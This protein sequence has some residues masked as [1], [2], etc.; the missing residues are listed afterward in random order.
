MNK[1]F[2]SHKSILILVILS[3]SN[4]TF[5]STN[6]AFDVAL[7]QAQNI[8]GAALDND[9]YQV[10]QN[11]KIFKKVYEML[12]DETNF[13]VVVEGDAD[14]RWYCQR[15]I[16]PNGDQTPAAFVYGTGVKVCPILLREENHWQIS[17]TLIHEAAHLAGLRNECQATIIEIEAYHAANVK[18][19]IPGYPQCYPNWRD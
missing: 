4:T 11:K 12:L 2:F 16:G 19:R 14:D 3:I 7:K 13:E 1:N 15:K 6:K 18:P 9:D 10:G 17:Q 5:G 8:V